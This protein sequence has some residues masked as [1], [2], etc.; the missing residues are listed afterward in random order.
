V[1]ACAWNRAVLVAAMLLGCGV[2]FADEPAGAHAAAASSCPPG[3]HSPEL[4][5]P[6]NEMERD[7]HALAPRLAFVDALLAQGCYADAVHVLEGGEAFHPRNS[8]LQSRLRDARSMLSEQRYFDGLGRAAETAKHERNLL[9]CRQLRDVAACDEALEVTPNDASLLGAKAD[10][11]MKTNRLA[12]AIP[13]YR[14]ALEASPDDGDLQ[15][16]ARDAET[17]RQAA[18]AECL[19]GQ[20]DAALQA[21]QMAQLRGASDEFSVQ[22]RRA[23]LLQSTDRPAQALDAYI[24]ASILKPGD[25]A[26]ARAIVA[27]TESS[28]RNDALTL[29]ARGNALLTLRRG[30]EALKVLKQAQQL[31]PALPDVKLHL[32]AAQA[33]VRAEARTREL[34]ATTVATSKA[35]LADASAS[36]APA[37][38]P[39]A[40]KYLNK[41]PASRSN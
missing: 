12:D 6:R 27:L 21:C 23:L 33:L 1:K 29:S 3:A 32:A 2:C 37:S 17:K 18:V 20:A 41:E 11:L 13:L 24:A 31:A 16:K 34:V 40:R 26:V 22:A 4:D 30:A 8:S 39:A 35:E 28:G 15:S 7:D 10:A 25:P 5:A 38:Q 19:N 14:R 36:P 9:R